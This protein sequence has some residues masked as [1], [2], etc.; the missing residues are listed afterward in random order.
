[1]GNSSSTNS[2]QQLVNESISILNTYTTNCS[3]L[4]Q[5]QIKINA[6]NCPGLQTSQIDQGQYA[7][8][9]VNCISTEMTQSAIQADIT[10]AMT[11]S[12]EAI[13]QSLGGIA[14]ADASNIADTSVKLGIQISNTYTSDCLTDEQN[15]I[16]INC[17]DSAGVFIG[18]ISQQQSLDSIT[19]CTL[20]ADTVNNIKTQLEQQL[21]QSAIA[22]E[23][24]SLSFMFI[25]IAIILI[26][27]IIIF[28]II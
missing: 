24:N 7:V 18:P 14:D 10:Q 21:S 19:K 15:N 17:S 5:N 8:L 6:Q 13:T 28:G 2:A 11:Q 3:T 26:I 9:N 20:Q 22:K 25:F 16:T 4:Q 12:A 1:M 27:G 23:E